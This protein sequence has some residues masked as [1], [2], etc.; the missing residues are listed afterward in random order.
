[1]IIS[2]INNISI[3]FGDVFLKFS[4]I[5]GLLNIG[6][7]GISEYFLKVYSPTPS[8]PCNVIPTPFKFWLF[9]QQM[10]SSTCLPS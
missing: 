7:D 9:S 4:Q 6:S 3:T 10:Q 1:M 8:L 2:T 5:K